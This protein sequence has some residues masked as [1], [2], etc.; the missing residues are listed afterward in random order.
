MEGGGKLINI[1]PSGVPAS[2]GIEGDKGQ[3]KKGESN[4]CF[5]L[6][7]TGGEKSSR[8]K[9]ILRQINGIEIHLKGIDKQ[10]DLKPY[11][12]W[13]RGSGGKILTFE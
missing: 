8:R 6:E 2:R 12:G 4:R 11:I 7:I 10:S 9:G 1:I 3:R 13:G 5:T